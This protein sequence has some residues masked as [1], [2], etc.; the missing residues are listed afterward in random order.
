MKKIRLSI[1]LVLLGFL[2]LSSCDNNNAFLV[3][4]RT[5]TPEKIEQIKKAQQQQEEE[6][7]DNE[8]DNEEKGKEE[9]VDEK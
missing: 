5:A 4:R 8:K 7:R 9:K 2:C 1:S 6:K 3:N